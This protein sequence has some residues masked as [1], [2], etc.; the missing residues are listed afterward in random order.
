MK[1]VIIESPFSGDQEK[2]RDYA[3]KCLLD[4]LDRGEA[5][6]ASHLLYTQVLDD[7]KPEQRTLGIEAG[8]AWGKKA[9]LTAVYIDLGISKGME[10]GI[11]RAKSEGR[12]IEYRKLCVQNTKFADKDTKERCTRIG[13]QGEGL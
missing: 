3:M 9:D 1:L 8:L 13:T 5:P 12:E 11:D 2:N 7:L 4:S 6:F 10:F